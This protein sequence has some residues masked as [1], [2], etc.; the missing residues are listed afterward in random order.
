MACRDLRCLKANKD[1]KAEGERRG[2]QM[3]PVC[4]H[5]H[6]KSGSDSRHWGGAVLMRAA[7]FLGVVF[8]A[9]ADDSNRVEKDS[10]GGVARDRQGPL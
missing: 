1:G 7:F 4:K 8:Q 6:V 3:S 2:Q 5:L 9:S 10:T